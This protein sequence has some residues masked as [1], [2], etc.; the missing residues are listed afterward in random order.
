[1]WHKCLTIVPFATLDVE[2]TL[3]LECVAWSE[4]DAAKKWNASWGAY[5]YRYH[6]ASK[7]KAVQAKSSRNL[8]LFGVR[9]TQPC[10]DVQKNQPFQ[11]D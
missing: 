8:K 5:I 9:Q 1:M 11:T 3:S 6:N 2:N 4:N 7:Q 10:H